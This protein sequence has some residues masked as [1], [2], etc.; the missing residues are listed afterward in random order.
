MIQGH[1]G[2][3]YNLAQR[4]G[5]LP[6]DI[7]DMS[8]NVN[9]LGPPPG[10]TEFLK[11]NL[12]AI[13]A[14]PEADAHSAISE[15]AKR[16]GLDHECIAA[17]NGTTQLIYAIPKAL[18]SR[19]VVIVAPTYSDYADACKMHN[20]P[21][22]YSLTEDSR[23]FEPDFDKLEKDIISADTVFICNPNNPTGVLISANHLE[24]FCK[25]FPD[26]TFIIDESYLPFVRDAEQQ[27]LLNRG[28]GN[29]IVLHSMSKIFRIPGLRIGFAAASPEIIQKLMRYALPWSVN[30]LAAAAVIWLMTNVAEIDTFIL[31]TRTYSEN[32]RDCFIRKL[33]NSLHITVFPSTTSFILAKLSP[34][35]QAE[36]ICEALAKE[37]ILIR[38]CS[39][40]KGLSEQF[41]RISL[42]T[43]EIN[44]MLAERLSDL[45]RFPADRI[46]DYG[47]H[48]LHGAKPS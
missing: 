8:S 41:I 21:Y 9:P 22:Q 7:I 11:N 30:S 32:E 2:N 40:F 27:S 15:F 24:S 26:K 39:N 14:L 44:R 33:E 45:Q 35:Y 5:C 13:V 6:S 10:L 36:T 19:N 31:K 23:N 46:T 37:K 18:E 1:G 28:I 3:I 16:Y 17:G 42:K 38:N 29:V 20:V 25:A 34:S 12:N 43:S 4:L 47:L 48:F